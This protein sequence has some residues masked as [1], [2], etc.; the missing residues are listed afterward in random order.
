LQVTRDAEVQLDALF[1]G[2]VRRDLPIDP[3][4]LGS[5]TPPACRAA[6]D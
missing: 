1:Q 5:G 2:Y 3:K 4:T 6:L